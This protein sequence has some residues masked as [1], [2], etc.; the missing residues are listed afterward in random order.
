[1]SGFEVSAG[2]NG[3]MK[4]DILRQPI[5]RVELQNNLAPICL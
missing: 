4:L 1:M 3:L 5:I 2:S